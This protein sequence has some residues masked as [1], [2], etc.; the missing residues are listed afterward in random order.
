MPKVIKKADGIKVKGRRIRSV[1]NSTDPVIVRNNNADAGMI[2]Y[3]FTPEPVII[4]SFIQISHM[5]LVIGVGGG[6]TVGKR[7]AHLALNAEFM[8]ALAVIVNSPLAEKD[9]KLVVEE[10]GIPVIATVVSENQVEA[11]IRAGADIINA[12]AASKTPQLVEDIKREYDI[13]VMA[14]GGP[15]DESILNT[16]EAGASAISYKP[17]GINELMSELMERYRQIEK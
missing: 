1:L 7:V 2:V 5:P 17:P 15:T 13:Q 11:K 9:L 8:G 16:I 4:Q 12:A 6:T 3:P 10:V 14:T